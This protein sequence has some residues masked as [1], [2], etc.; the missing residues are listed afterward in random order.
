MELKN[1]CFDYIFKKKKLT[2]EHFEE[3]IY[4][5]TI[6]IFRFLHYIFKCIFIKLFYNCAF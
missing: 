2:T 1:S 6:K 4:F 5:G 3:L